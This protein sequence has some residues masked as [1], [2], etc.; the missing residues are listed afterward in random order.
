MAK[1]RITK[2]LQKFV[3]VQSALYNHFNQERHLYNRVNFK[4][5]RA[6]ALADWRRIAA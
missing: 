4:D 1:F 5:M 2:S 3:S 6:A